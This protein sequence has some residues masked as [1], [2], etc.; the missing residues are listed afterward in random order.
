MMDTFKSIDQYFAGIQYD[1]ESPYA[2]RVE[3]LKK[4]QCQYQVDEKLEIM[5]MILAEDQ[6]RIQKTESVL[7]EKQKLVSEKEKQYTLIH[8]TNQ[9]FD[10]YE[11]FRQEAELLREKKGEMEQK[12]ERV[13]RQKTA[14]YEIKPFADAM[15]EAKAVSGVIVMVPASK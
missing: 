11:A 2:Q 1:A 6:T 9:L 10:T 13:R 7:E 14:V 12:A 5:Q 3:E 8:A 15:Q 4:E